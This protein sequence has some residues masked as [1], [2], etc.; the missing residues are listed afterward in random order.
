MERTSALAERIHATLNAMEEEG[1]NLNAIAAEGIKE[2]CDRVRDWTPAWFESS[3]Q[4][5]KGKGSS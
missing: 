5:R 1:W 2:R 3:E 4:C